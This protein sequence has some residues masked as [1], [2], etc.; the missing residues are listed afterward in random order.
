MTD[1]V[2][3]RLDEDDIATLSELARTIWHAHYPGIISAAQIDY[4]LGQRYAPEAIRASLASTCWEVAWDGPVMVGFAHAFADTAPRT[5]KL[6]KLYVHPQ[7]QRR[8]I[9]AALLARIGDDARRAGAT[10][11][12]LRVNRHNAVALAAYA[13]YGFQRY[14]AEVL[15]IGNGFVMDDYLLEMHLG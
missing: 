13:K 4:M 6:D 9:G 11:L 10:R 1:A 14:G 15:E 12:V 2:I 7:R 8:G 3:R 5:W